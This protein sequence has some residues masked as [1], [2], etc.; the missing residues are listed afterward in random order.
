LIYFS[1][2]H[3]VRNGSGAHHPPIQWVPGALS[4][5]IK[6][7]RREADYLPPPSAKVKNAWLHLHS[8]NTSPWSGT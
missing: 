3:R 8:L 7:P 6:L 5:R 2:H 4:L 1:F